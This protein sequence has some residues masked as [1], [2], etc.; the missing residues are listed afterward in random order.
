MYVALPEVAMEETVVAT[1]VLDVGK[2][3]LQ[4]STYVCTH[5]HK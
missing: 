2:I 5:V 3:V 1:A 4:I